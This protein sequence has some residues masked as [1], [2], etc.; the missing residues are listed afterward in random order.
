LPR[1]HQELESRDEFLKIQLC[2]KILQ[3]RELRTKPNAKM[4]TSGHLT[5][6]VF[7]P[8]YSTKTYSRGGATQ[9]NEPALGDLSAFRI[10][11]HSSRT[12]FGKLIFEEG[13]MS[14]DTREGMA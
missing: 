11:R 7:I 13:L 8:R 14:F 9:G 12:L 5:Y 2:C 6:K 3:A 1:C 4:L 10:S